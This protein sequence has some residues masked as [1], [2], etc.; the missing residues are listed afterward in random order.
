MVVCNLTSA[1]QIFHA[2]RRQ[3]LRPARKPLIIMTPKSLLRAKEAYS[4]LEEF[5][6]GR[7][8]RVIREPS[9]EVAPDKVRK[10][11]LCSGKVY[12]DLVNKRTEKKI[13]DVAIIRLEQ[14][15]P[16]PQARLLEALAPY[17]DGT[18]LVWVQ[19]DPWNMGGWY[20]L[21]ARLPG[22]LG[23][24]LPLSCVA[25][26]ESASPATGSAEAHDLEHKRLMAQAFA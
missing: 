9:A 26:D 13:T 1:S 6:D 2:L 23:A 18:P 10:V 16:L 8:H 19:E 5:T 15:Y 24:L 17:R 14:L 3:V 12:W 7:F 4:P 20:F 22:L 21:A 25:R 11:L